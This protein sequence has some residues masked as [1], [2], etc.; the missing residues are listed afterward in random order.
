MKKILLALTLIL[1]IQLTAQTTA[2]DYVKIA[3]EQLDTNP[4]TSLARQNF[5]KALKIDPIH[6]TA[7]YEFS[8]YSIDKRSYHEAID[9]LTTLIDNYPGHSD[10]HWQR[11]RVLV[12]K[13]ALPSELKTAQE[14]L[15]RAIALGFDDSAKIAKAKSLIQKYSD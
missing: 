10:Y 11:V 15:D 5:K 13:N 1:G 2:D 9:L 14:D 4:L 7:L 8:M 3:L 12:R 6:E